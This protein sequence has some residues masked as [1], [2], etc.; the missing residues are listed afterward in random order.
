MDNS[1]ENHKQDRENKGM[2]FT[3][4]K[5]ATSGI[6]FVLTAITSAA[7]AGTTSLPA[8]PFDMKVRCMEKMDK[9]GETPHQSNQICTCFF[10]QLSSQS[11]ELAYLERW[12][13]Q[14]KG[15]AVT[16]KVGALVDTQA[17][18]CIGAE[19]AASKNTALTRKIERKNAQTEQFNAMAGMEI[20]KLIDKDLQDAPT[21]KNTCDVSLTF[22]SSGIVTAT[23]V[24]HER[25]ACP[26]WLY[27][28]LDN[29]YIHTNNLWR[30]M[31]K[32][33]FTTSLEIQP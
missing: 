23:G 29:G 6:F 27:L 28:R 16:G 20:Q 4:R 22:N 30:I 25:D 18:E 3:S 9:T 24:D 13:I 2:A 31:V 33:S 12:R 32:K 21:L 7:A 1:P 15:V 14:H 19:K 17:T 8:V 10:Q 26:E 5:A 11:G